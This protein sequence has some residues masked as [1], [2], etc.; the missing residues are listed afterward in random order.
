MS[1]SFTISSFTKINAVVPPTVI[2]PLTLRL[3]LMIVL[4]LTVRPVNVGLSVS[5]IVAPAP[6][7]VAVRFP[8]TKL[9]LEILFA[10]PTIEPSSLIVR[11]VIASAGAASTQ[12]T[13]L[14]V[15]IKT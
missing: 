11:P 14:P 3:E 8:L 7:A 2:F 9:I 1:L 5:V 6:D 4:P 10:V 12:S 13:P 15:E